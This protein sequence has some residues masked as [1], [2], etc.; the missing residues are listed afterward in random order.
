MSHSPNSLSRQKGGQDSPFLRACT[1]SMMNTI[2]MA[3][4][5]VNKLIPGTPRLRLPRLFGPTSLGSS[6]FSSH[7]GGSASIGCCS[8]LSISTECS[9]NQPSCSSLRCRKGGVESQ[10]ANLSEKIVENGES[11]RKVILLVCA[12]LKD[13]D[14]KIMPLLLRYHP[15]FFKSQARFWHRQESGRAP[16]K[17]G[18]KT[19]HV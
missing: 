6:G 4:D 19:T 10:I 17:V 13:Q 16:Y 9:G 7:L 1:R 5:K 2:F 15:N 11:A 3:Q 8:T 12:Q 14:S 18:R